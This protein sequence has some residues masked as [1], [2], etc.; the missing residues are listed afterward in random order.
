MI[1]LKYSLMSFQ[2]VTVIVLWLIMICQ[3]PSDYMTT[4]TQ[5]VWHQR[6]MAVMNMFYFY[7]TKASPPIIATEANGR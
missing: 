4:T 6:K 2:I 1:N 5:R 3:I 7:S